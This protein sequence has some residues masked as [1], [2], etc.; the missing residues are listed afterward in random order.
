MWKLSVEH[1]NKF[2]KPIKVIDTLTYNYLETKNPFETA[3][4]KMSAR[5]K[6]QNPTLTNKKSPTGD[7]VRKYRIEV[8]NIPEV[9][10]RK[11]KSIIKHKYKK[12]P[13]LH[14]ENYGYFYI[15]Q[16]SLEPCY[17]LGFLGDTKENFYRYLNKVIS[18]DLEETKWRYEN[19]IVQVVPNSICSRK[20][21]VHMC[22]LQLLSDYIADYW[23]L[24][25]K[26]AIPKVKEKTFNIMRQKVSDFSDLI[27][28]ADIESRLFVKNSFEWSFL[29]KITLKYRTPFIR[30]N[31]WLRVVRRLTPYNIY[32]TWTFCVYWFLRKKN[33]K[34]SMAYDS[35][36]I[37]SQW[38]VFYKSDVF[39]DYQNSF[40]TKGLR[41]SITYFYK[42]IKK[43]K[44]LGLAISK[45]LL[46]VIDQSKP[47]VFYIGC[48]RHKDEYRIRRTL[49]HDR[50]WWRSILWNKQSLTNQNN[51]YFINRLVF[52]FFSKLTSHLKT[53]QN[54]TLLYS[55]LIHDRSL[56][57]IIKYP[58]R[59]YA[60]KKRH[61]A[62]AR[63]HIRKKFFQVARRVIAVKQRF[64]SYLKVFNEYTS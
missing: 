5:L 46:L 27:I 7:Q 15:R 13:E 43:L 34:T 63:W 41:N 48:K 54:L 61:R 30:S 3:L 21:I 33:I 9:Y 45:L 16:L 11:A 23:F 58:K 29:L 12:D 17:T 47:Y 56:L 42:L 37:N 44:L 1:R 60:Y 32:D 40:I 25:K 52:N 38:P 62:F 22:T 59:R 55:R 8:F 31:Q 50:Q 18:K 2:K 57:N 4:F 49:E 35:Y 39:L 51:E 6:K 19:R 36:L 10:N 53:Y 28:W 20:C 24:F 26:P 64:V 14:L